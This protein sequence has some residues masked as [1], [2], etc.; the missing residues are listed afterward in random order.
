[1]IFGKTVYQFYGLNSVCFNYA[2][3]NPYRLYILD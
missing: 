3:L 1:M 2:L